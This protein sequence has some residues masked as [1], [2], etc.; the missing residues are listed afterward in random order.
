MS[1]I[2]NNEQLYTADGDDIVSMI[3]SDE[4]NVSN[5]EL[6]WEFVVNWISMRERERKGYVGKLLSHVRTGLTRYDYFNKKVLIDRPLPFG[7]FI[8]VLFHC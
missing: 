5:E 4:L 1:V 6:V 7:I 8:P 2:K 3:S